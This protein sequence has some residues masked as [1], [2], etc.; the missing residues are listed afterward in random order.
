MRRMALLLWIVAATFPSASFLFALPLVLAAAGQP[1][2]AAARGDN[3]ACYARAVAELQRRS[4][5]GYAVYQAMRDKKL[6]LTWISCD[7]LQTELSTAV[8]ESVHILTEEN[9]A[10]PL[11]DG[12]SI[13][14]PHDVSKFFP[15]REMAGGLN[16]ADA[17]VQN[18]LGPNGASSKGDFMYLLDELNAYTHDLDA[19]I[20]LV[21]LQRRDLQIDHRDGL[22]ALMSFVMRYVDKAKKTQPATWQGLHQP[23]PRATIKA[24]WDQAE[25]TLAASCGLPA[26]GMH[27]RDYISYV[28]EKKNAEALA[29]LLERAP[30]CPSE[31]LAPGAASSTPH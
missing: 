15:P 20:A 12:R 30:V 29:D 8:H 3:S 2:S 11:L 27:D 18:Y 13:P 10:F 4:S 1:A 14:R 6:F 5:A 7:D 22:A 25:K 26:F 24:L 28:C 21:P 17:Y 16:A 31:C 23:E 19:A 9:D